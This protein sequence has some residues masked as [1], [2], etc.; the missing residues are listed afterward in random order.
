MDMEMDK[1]MVLGGEFVLVFLLS[2]SVL[3]SML[4][5]LAHHHPPHRPSSPSLTMYEYVSAASVRLIVEL[6][7]AHS[8]AIKVE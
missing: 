8:K 3:L 1:G 2:P 6:A 7:H 5:T 4:A